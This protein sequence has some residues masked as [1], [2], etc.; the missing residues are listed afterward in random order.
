MPP[1]AIQLFISHSSK[2]EEIVNCLV[3]IVVK[4]FRLPA[5]SIRCTSLNGYKLPVGAKIDQLKEEVLNAKVL[6]GVLTPN[7]MSSTYA[8]FELGCRWGTDKPLMPIVCVSNGKELLSDPLKSLN[9]T[10][11]CDTVSIL[12]F[13]DSLGK[14]LGKKSQSATVYMK[15]VEDLVDI[16]KKKEYP[17]IAHRLV[18]LE[19]LAVKEISAKYK[20]W[21]NEYE[22]TK[23]PEGF[24][25]EIKS[26]VEGDDYSVR[27]VFNTVYSMY[28]AFGRVRVDKR[29]EIEREVRIQRELPISKKRLLVVCKV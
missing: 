3:N 13:I 27:A 11:T 12:H 9:Y 29:F 15:E 24:F 16:V 14:A 2:D 25:D 23:F 1:K 20:L 4:A 26:M 22:N 7:T 17:R 10:E 8:M 5:S 18:Y 6:V 28:Q 19:S 21:R